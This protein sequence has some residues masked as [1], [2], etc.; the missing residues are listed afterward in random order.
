METRFDTVANGNVG[1]GHWNL[2]VR[3]PVE[4]SRLP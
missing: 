4:I 2:T 3:F 1:N